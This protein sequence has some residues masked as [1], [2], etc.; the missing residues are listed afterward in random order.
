MIA[1]DT[2][3][4]VNMLWSYVYFGLVNTIVAMCLR[5]IGPVMN[6]MWIFLMKMFGYSIYDLMFEYNT[7]QSVFDTLVR[8]GVCVFSTNHILN[9][10][11]FNGY[12]VYWVSGGFVVLDAHVSSNGARGERTSGYSYETIRIITT[13][14]IKTYL[15]MKRESLLSLIAPRENE[16]SQFVLF[17]DQIRPIEIIRRPHISFFTAQQLSTVND[18]LRRIKNVWPKKQKNGYPLIDRTLLHSATGGTGKSMIGRIL[19]EQTGGTLICRKGFSKSFDF[20]LARCSQTD[21]KIVQLD[22]FDKQFSSNDDSGGGDDDGDRPFAPYRQFRHY[23][24]AGPTQTKR[25]I[26]EEKIIHIHEFFDMAG[27][28]NRFN[29]IIVIATT[30]D[31]ASIEK[32]DPAL[33]HRWDRIEEYFT[34]NNDQAQS[35]AS[36]YS[37]QIYGSNYSIDALKNDKNEEGDDIITPRTIVTAIDKH[38]AH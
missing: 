18:I 36:S 25:D 37:K 32:I 28:Y 13:E 20:D 23:P 3:T 26:I 16:L 8:E 17:S 19:A 2:D 27:E 24:T 11:H 30:N 21:L 31:I 10:K 4:V 29:N 6:M 15:Y 22:E 34:L 5:H 9:T 12:A 38:F 35:F 1:K 14:K 33:H 7:F